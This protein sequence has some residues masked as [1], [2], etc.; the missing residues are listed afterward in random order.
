MEPFDRAGDE[1]VLQA[2]QTVLDAGRDASYADL[3]ASEDFVKACA[4]AKAPYLGGPMLGGVTGDGARVWMRTCRPVAAGAVKGL[5]AIGPPGYPGGGV[6]GTASRTP[7]SAKGGPAMGEPGRPP[8]PFFASASGLFLALVGATTAFAAPGVRQEV[9]DDWEFQFRTM[10]HGPIDARTE[11]QR[12]DAQAAADRAGDRDRVDAELRRIE[13]LLDYW[14][15]REPDEPRWQTFRKQYEA[16][17]TAAQAIPLDP[18]YLNPRNEG[19]RRKLYLGVES[20]RRQVSR[21]R[22]LA[23]PGPVPYLLRN[24]ETAPG[25]SLDDP[26][27]LDAHAKFWPT[28]RDQV[29]VVLR[30]TKALLNYWLAK[31]PA[32]PKWQAFGK[33]LAE[34]K[35]SAKAT[36]P[37]LTGQ[38]AARHQVYLDLCALRRETVLAS[39]LLDFDDVLFI[40]F[41]DVGN[42]LERNRYYVPPGGGLYAIRGFKSGS[43]RVVDLL[44]NA[45]PENGDYAGRSLSGGIVQRAELSYDGRTI[46]FAWAEPEAQAARGDSPRLPGPYHLFRISA[47]GGGL[48]QLTFGPWQDMDPYELPNGRIIFCSTRRKSGDRCCGCNRPSAFLHSMKA[49]GSDIICLSFHETHE[50]EP[51]VDNQGMVI[52]SRWDYVDRP[53]R[54]PRNL[55]ICYPDGTNPR[56][57]HGNNGASI[58]KG[59]FDPPIRGYYDAPAYLDWRHGPPLSEASVRA[60]PGSSRYVAVAGQHK[61]FEIEFE[62]KIEEKGNSGFY[63]RVGDKDSPVGTGIEV[64]IYASHGKPDSRLG[65]HDA[66]GLMGGPGIRPTKNA[67]KPAGEWNRFHVINK[68]DTLT[69]KPTGEIVNE[70]DLRKGWFANRPQTGW[71]GFQD[72]GLPPLA[73]EHQDP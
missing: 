43:P 65:D 31:E 34:L 72:H 23:P 15:V 36:K 24:D 16:Q 13:A 48:R 68:D 57:P 6:F 54:G 10:G 29:D 67:A 50:W 52:Y 32:S 49:D 11:P 35:A 47:D 46:Y 44:A 1:R 41:H 59:I 22:T 9:R 5:A 3:L 18:D 27:V 4:E 61:D 55:W 39:P 37:D 19:P 40:E 20:L 62:F 33:R 30:R 21:A 58:G 73:S 38:D 25:M 28:D 26:P 66:G 45:E 56:A 42:Y 51:S 64:Q 14:Q 60:V 70:A 17:K 2:A 8:A 69:V 7:C 12:I 63:F 53:A 71:I